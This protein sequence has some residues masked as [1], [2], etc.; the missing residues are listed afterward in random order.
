MMGV[1]RPPETRTRGTASTDE[2]MTVFSGVADTA[3]G[4]RGAGTIDRAR[5]GVGRAGR[6][7]KRFEQSPDS[8]I[9]FHGTPGFCVYV[10]PLRAPLSLGTAQL[11]RSVMPAL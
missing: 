5:T 8:Y 3:S 2:A 1:R 11:K 7:N 6:H 4:A 9:G 10:W